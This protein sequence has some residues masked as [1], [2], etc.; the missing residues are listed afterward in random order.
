M[1]GSDSDAR[2][3]CR[4]RLNGES[5]AVPDPLLAILREAIHSQPILAGSGPTTMVGLCMAKRL[6]LQDVID[7]V[8]AALRGGQF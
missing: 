3:D 5:T 1:L 8:L 4:S 2:P 7:L 6:R